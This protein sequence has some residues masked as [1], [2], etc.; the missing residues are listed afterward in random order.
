MLDEPIEE[1]RESNP[2]ARKKLIG[3]ISIVKN[4]LMKLGVQ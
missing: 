4:S 1:E 3:A 2:A